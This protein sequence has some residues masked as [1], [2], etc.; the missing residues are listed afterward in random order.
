MLTERSRSL[1]RHALRYR[2]QLRTWRERAKRLE[3]VRCEVELLRGADVELQHTAELLAE[4]RAAAVPHVP[5]EAPDAAKWRAKYEQAKSEARQLEAR[6]HE[7]E[8]EGPRF[9]E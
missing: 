6:V 4:A 1:A 8:N 7:L 2:A 3:H 9:E 5:V